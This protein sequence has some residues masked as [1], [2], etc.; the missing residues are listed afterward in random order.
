VER[1]VRRHIGLWKLPERVTLAYYGIR[2]RNSVRGDADA[3]TAHGANRQATARGTGS[4]KTGDAGEIKR[5][6]HR[7]RED[8]LRR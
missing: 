1:K 3:E 7:L 8:S 4:P 6:A 2:D 5:R